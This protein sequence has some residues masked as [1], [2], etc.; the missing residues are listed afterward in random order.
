MMFRPGDDCLCQADGFMIFFLR[1]RFYIGRVAR[2]DGIDRQTGCF[3]E[4][5][6]WFEVRGKKFD[7]GSEVVCSWCR[8]VIRYKHGF[9][10]FFR[11]LLGV[12]TERFCKHFGGGLDVCQSQIATC[13]TNPIRGTAGFRFVAWSVV[14]LHRLLFLP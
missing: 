11:R 3:I 5:K 9:Q 4:Y 6:G 7:Q 13:M 10:G 12:E 14:R 8:L 2:Q 1:D